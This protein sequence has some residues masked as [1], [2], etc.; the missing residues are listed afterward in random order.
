VFYHDYFPQVYFTNSFF[1]GAG[2][3]AGVLQV[4]LQ[5]QTTVKA[6]FQAGD[7]PTQS[8]FSDWIESSMPEWQVDAAIQVGG[9]GTGMLNVISSVSA[10]VQT[11]GAFG[12]QILAAPTTAII[13]QFVPGWV[14]DTTQQATGAVEFLSSVSATTHSAGSFGFNMLSSITTAAGRN[15]FSKLKCVQDFG[16][17]GNGVANDSAAIL[18]AEAACSAGEALYFPTGNYLFRSIVTITRQRPRWMGDGPKSTILTW[19]GSANANMITVGDGISQ[20]IGGSFTNFRITSATAMTGGTAL[21][22]HK[23]G[24]IFYDNVVIDGQDGSGKFANGIWCNEVDASVFRDFEIYGSSVTAPNG[25]GFSLNG[26]VG[27]GNKSDVYIEGAK[28]ANFSVGV[29]VGGAFGGFFM[30]HFDVINNGINLTID[31]TLAA[32]VNREIM[33]GIGAFDTPKTAQS[34]LINCPTLNAGVWIQFDGTWIAGANTFASASGVRITSAPQY[35]INFTG[36][37]IYLNNDG[38]EV[39]D[40]TSTVLIDGCSITNNVRGLSTATSADV[41]I[42]P[43][44]FINNSSSDI[45]AGTI[46]SGTPTAGTMRF[47][48]VPTPT[49]ALVGQV[50][51]NETTQ[52]LFCY[53]SGGWRALHT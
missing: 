45:P 26:S 22:F 39:L 35:S 25:T 24:R 8:Q 38:I 11:V 53:A 16:A 28:I 4:T 52:T 13:S 9:G 44:S 5:H 23:C 47:H 49:N 17:A 33:I 37:K 43:N 21:T 15:K 1:P 2:V 41:R 51:Y 48:P 50:H 32:E 14:G 3:S 30:N 40:K 27:A 34:V 7:A 10:T 20:N 6:W 12:L 42:G 36:C 31:E 29:H 18:A 19:D 46:L